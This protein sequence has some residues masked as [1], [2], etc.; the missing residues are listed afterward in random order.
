MRTAVLIFVITALTACA[1]TGE[2]SSYDPNLI[3][4]EEIEASVH[5]NV[6]D[7][8]QELRPRWLVTTASMSLRS[9]PGSV[10]FYVDGVRQGSPGSINKSIV[11]EIRYYP[12]AE[13]QARWGA[14]HQQG[15]IDIITRRVEAD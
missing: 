5:D 13:A 14:G 4:A 3:T 6:S 9:G 10:Q 1:T 8:I 7:I 15:A 12:P 2:G 11:R